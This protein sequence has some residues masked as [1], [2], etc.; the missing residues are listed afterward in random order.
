MNVGTHKLEVTFVPDNS[1][2]ATTEYSVNITVIKYTPK[3][4]WRTSNIIYGTPLGENQLCAEVIED[5]IPGKFSYSPDTGTILETGKHAI[6]VIFIPDSSA[7]YRLVNLSVDIE[8]SKYT[9]ILCWESKQYDIITVGQP[10]SSLNVNAHCQDNIPGY[11]KIFPEKGTILPIGSHNIICLF[12]PDD[13]KNYNQS[14]IL[15]D[16]KVLNVQPQ[17]VWNQPNDIEY[18]ELLS[19]LQLNASILSDYKGTLMYNPPLGEKLEIGT[20]TLSV[21]FLPFDESSSEMF[22]SKSVTIAVTKILPV[23]IWNPPKDLTRKLIN[24]SLFF[25]DT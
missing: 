22:I 24:N 2:Y 5:N 19:E 16:V 3:I 8:V 20:H 11:F 7:N 9:P 15:K 1:D 18:G 13:S 21:I 10:L 23:I 25:I 4:V 12:I 14:E 17:L 6:E